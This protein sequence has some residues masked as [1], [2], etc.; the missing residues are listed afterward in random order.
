MGEQGISVTDHEWGTEGLRGF[1]ALLVLYTHLLWPAAHLDSGYAPSEWF[2]WFEASQGAVLLFFILSGYVIGLTNK[3]PF[4]GRAF[5]HYGLR[6]VIRLVPLYWVAIALSVW[7][8]P[9]DSLGVVAGNL[10]FLQNSLGYGSVSMPVLQANTNLWSLNYEFL[11][12]LLFPLVWCLSPGRPL[13]PGL[14]GLAVVLG[15]VLVPGLGA[16]AGCYALGWLFWLAG[17]ALAFAPLADRD[18]LVGRLPWPSL[19]LLW[20]ATW[21]TKPLWHFMHRFGLLPLQEAWIDYSYLDFLPVSVCL[22]LAASGRRPRYTRLLV[23]VSFVFPLAF[24]A[25]VCLRG[26]LMM[27]AFSVDTVFLLAALVLCSWKPSTRFIAR[28]AWVGSI[29]YGLYIFQRPVQ[30][31]IL[32]ASW[33]PTGT[34]FSYSL[35]L[36]LCLV[37]TL[38]LSWFL[39]RMLQ[40]CLRR[41]FLAR[42]S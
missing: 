9:V 38:T 3:A 42:V 19:L 6:R 14:L 11:Y 32:D 28:L 41:W 4:S 13:V 15:A 5:R 18:A 29:S 34:V 21:H 39:E 31:F 33:I 17:Y 1:A 26:R 20:F 36:T 25:W 2:Q 30:W 10:S 35:R 40:P 12:Y 7:V 27:D 16:V 37:L 24:L 8:R 22:L 23:L